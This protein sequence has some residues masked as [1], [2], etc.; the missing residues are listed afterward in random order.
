MDWPTAGVIVGIGA[1]TIGIVFKLMPNNDKLDKFIELAELDKF[2]ELAEDIKEAVF[3]IKTLH[4]SQ[5]KIFDSHHDK[6]ND[7]RDSTFITAKELEATEKLEQ[8]ILETN[9]KIIEKQNL[10]LEKVNS[11]KVA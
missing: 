7:I 9:T 8:R 6:L 2:I 3:K 11:L 10:I 1:P 4:E 5:N